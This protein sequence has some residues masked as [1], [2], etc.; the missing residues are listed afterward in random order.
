MTPKIRRGRRRR[1]PPPSPEQLA[2]VLEALLF[3]ADEPVEV[4][5]LSRSLNVPRQEILLALDALAADARVRGVRLQLN[6]SRVQM[7]SA[8][9]AG[10][11]VEQ[12]LGAEQARLSDAALEVLAIVAYRQ[13][14]TRATIDSIRGVASEHAVATLLGR[15]LVE[16][17]GKS[18]AIGHA[19]LLGTTQ[20]FLEY[21]GLERPD[22][23]PPIQEGEVAG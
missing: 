21:F 6:G 1:L 10:T 19:A 2:M 3:V 23:L 4:G 12:F 14:V 5:A 22:N 15:G 13:P 9:E 7:V 16:E 11:W 20:R 8:P 17:V 18:D